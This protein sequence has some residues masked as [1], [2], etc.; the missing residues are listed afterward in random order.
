MVSES[1]LVKPFLSKRSRQL[2]GGEKRILEVLLIVH[3]T[4]QYILI[5]K[6]FNGIA[7]VI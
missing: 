2:S 6:P 3:S 4:A 5:D 7:P 1:P